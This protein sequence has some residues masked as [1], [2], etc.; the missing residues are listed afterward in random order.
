MTPPAVYE[1]VK[2]FVIN[3]YDV[4]GLEIIR[5][6]WPDTDYKDFD[7]T[8]KIVIDNP[9][10]SIQAEI[11]EYYLD[12]NIKFF[13][14]VDGKTPPLKHLDYITLII[15]NSPIIY[16]NGANIN[17]GFITNLDEYNAIHISSNLDRELKALTPKK[18]RNKYNLPRGVVSPVRLKKYAKGGKELY[19]PKGEVKMSQNLDHLR[20]LKFKLYGV[21]LFLSDRLYDVLDAQ[22]NE[23]AV[24]I[25]LSEA[26][27]GIIERLNNAYKSKGVKKVQG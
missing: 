1:V 16:E 21:P 13:L 17:T 11:I 19:F 26:E 20:K 27:R 23:D 15:V 2:N 24:D 8:D 5:P 25:E 6:F 4:K 22:L 10:F 9:P 14:F 12:K 3:T 18:N 7:Y